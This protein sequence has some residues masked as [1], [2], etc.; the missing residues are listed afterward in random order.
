MGGL[1][2]WREKLFQKCPV[3]SLQK[4]GLPYLRDYSGGTAIQQ[5]ADS[6]LKKVKY[7]F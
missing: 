3:T 7:Q 5:K 1:G 2:I 4:E 6:D